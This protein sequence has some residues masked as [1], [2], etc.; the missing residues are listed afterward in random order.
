[1]KRFLSVF[2]VIGACL[3]GNSAV[4]VS[5]GTVGGDNSSRGVSL[6]TNTTAGTNLRGNAGLAH[7]YKTNQRNTYYMVTQMDVDTAC[8]QKLFEC[9]AEYCGDTAVVPGVNPTKCTYASPNELYNYA[10]LCLQRDTE[11]LLP[12]YN[13]NTHVATGGI[14]TAARLCPQYIQQEMTSYLSMMNM[15]E[16]LSKSSSDLC[17]SR[18]R[19]LEAAMSCH[20]VALAYGTETDSKL[21]TYLT[22]A[23]GAGV[24]GGSAE[25]VTRFATAGNVGA[26][27]WG[28]AE[29][30]VSL[31]MNSKGADW[32]AAVDSVLAS[33]TNRMNLACGDNQ[34]LN[35]VSHPTGNSGTPTLQAI[36]T[37]AL[38]TL[39]P[40]NTQ[41][42]VENPYAN[43][44]IAMEVT[45]RSELYNYDMAYSVV[46]GAMTQDPMAV[47]AF[48][49]SGQID[50]MQQA[51][52]R[53]TK[54]FV[55]RDSSRCY[56]IPVSELEPHERSLVSQG[57]ANC[58]SQ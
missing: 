33:Y 7:A 18:R 53:G 28:W 43:Q 25:M 16:Q 13:T 27:V 42:Q 49:N 39:Y 36:A 41:Q 9:F 22:D 32:Q 31:D 57:Y 8:R 44:G 55:I 3:L 2:G 48:L 14:N 46:H 11:V 29:K 47:N 56:M 20:A 50:D 30:I 1:M 34:Q 10:L 58:V 23:C 19:E 6:V 51:Y 15:A 24:P 40:T 45:S 26:N 52:I 21:R 54:V 38:G 4:A 17:I 12:Q 35:I 37:V 5:A